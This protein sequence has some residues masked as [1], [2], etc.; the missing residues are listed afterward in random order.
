VQWAKKMAVAFISGE[1]CL[2]VMRDSS[3]AAKWDRLHQKCTWA[4]AF[5]KF[6]FVE[7]WFTCYQHEFEP[8][9]IYQLCDDGELCGLLPLARHRRNQNWTVAGAHQCEYQMW[10]AMEEKSAIFI[11]ESLRYLINY[12]RLKK[13]NFR[14]IIDAKLMEWTRLGEW[15]EHV[16]INGKKRPVIDLEQRRQ[17]NKHFIIKGNQS[18]LK[19]LKQI[20]DVRFERILSIEEFEAVLPEIEALYDFRLGAVYG[21]CPFQ[22]DKNKSPFHRR[23]MEKV[24]LLHVTLMRVGNSIAS[25]HVGN[26][27]G[28]VV[29]IGL[30]SYSPRLSSVSPVYLHLELLAT[31]LAQEN[32]KLFD[33][34]PGDE[35][36]KCL[37]AN[38]IDTVYDLHVYSG[39]WPRFFDSLKKKLRVQTANLLSKAGLSQQVLWIAFR[40]LTPRSYR[41]G[42]NAVR[43][44][45]GA[46]RGPARYRVNITCARDLPR[47]KVLNENN[48][49]ELFGVNGGSC[50]RYQNEF[51]RNAFKRL[52]DGQRL[53]T[54]LR[55][56][57]L[58]FCAWVFTPGRKGRAGLKGRPAIPSDVFIKDFFVDKAYAD[59]SFLREALLQILSDAAQSS[60]LKEMH[61]YLPR[62]LQDL[63]G[64]MD[65]IGVEFQG[66]L[67]SNEEAESRETLGTE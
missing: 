1:E 48:F 27:N 11:Q 60:H 25:F 45:F 47:P 43:R 42:I 37:F 65:S 36:Y 35:Q 57:R 29:H 9:I 8:V 53:Y 58:I 52:S 49:R 15:K 46:W 50:D 39:K 17:S 22:S 31:E 33:L 38:R 12:H 16:W 67:K 59:S 64:A 20:G 7:A 26:T 14:F 2:S 63:R 21:T 55:E 28:E 32:F 62:R 4:T 51:I 41:F 3:F 24:D 23:M 56:G 30:H 5:Q 19:R 13:I 61:V 6:D 34:T 44:C 54:A 66:L 18:K 10:I 40:S